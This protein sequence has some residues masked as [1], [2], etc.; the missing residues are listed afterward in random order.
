MVKIINIP[1]NQ[2]VNLS[3]KRYGAIQKFNAVSFEFNFF[4]RHQ[5][6]VSN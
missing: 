3:E 1:D 5:H 2:K 4:I 6:K